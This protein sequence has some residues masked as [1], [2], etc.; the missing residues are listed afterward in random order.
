MSMEKRR[1]QRDLIVEFQFLKEIVTR[2]EAENEIA[3]GQT[4]N[5]LIR[6]WDKLPR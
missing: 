6:Q 2:R 5:M 4:K 1:T 3:N